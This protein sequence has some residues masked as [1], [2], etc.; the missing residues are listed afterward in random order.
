M[1]VLEANLLNDTL[2]F[3]E[4]FSLKNFQHCEDK[5]NENVKFKKGFY[6]GGRIEIFS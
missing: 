6:N 1:K 4:F 3:I 5:K 2:N